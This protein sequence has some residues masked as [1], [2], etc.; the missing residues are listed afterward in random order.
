MVNE[1]CG[2]W[3]SDPPPLPGRTSCWLAVDRS[4]LVKSKFLTTHKAILQSSCNDWFF[5]VW[6]GAGTSAVRDAVG[7]IA[8]QEHR[9]SDIS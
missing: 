8:S 9:V 3:V 6:L 1:A 2:G 5:M 4:R 7:T